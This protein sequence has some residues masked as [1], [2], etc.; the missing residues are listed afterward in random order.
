MSKKNI[1]LVII[2]LVLVAGILVLIYRPGLVPGPSSPGVPAKA[3]KKNVT[4]YI[5]A[6]TQKIGEGQISPAEAKTAAEPSNPGAWRSLGRAQYLAG[7][8]EAA[9]QS[10][11][12]AITLNGDDPQFY[13]DL[14]RVYEA[15][16]NFA[17][18]EEY[19]KKAIELNDNEI[20]AVKSSNS[21]MVVGTYGLVTPYTAL[22]GLYL[23]LKKADEAVMVLKLGIAMNPKYPD[24]YQLLAAAYKEAGNRA[25]AAE[26]EKN[27]K[28]LVPDIPAAS[29][30]P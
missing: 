13:V 16:G 9:A 27:F 18:A 30:T 7:D 22:G 8:P 15:E 19:Y 1:I 12:K 3:P 5:D 6:A 4:Y 25:K 28:A 23:R 24:F 10:L 20:K 21:A 26:A 14:G 17:K 29:S 2:L 11:N